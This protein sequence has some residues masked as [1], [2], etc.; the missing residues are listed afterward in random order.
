MIGKIFNKKVLLIAIVSTIFIF[1]F[2]YWMTISSNDIFR[3]PIGG[4]API[5]T[6]IEAQYSYDPD[7]KNAAL[8]LGEA[9]QQAI[10]DPNHAEEISLILDI[11]EACAK[12]VVEKKHF[13]FDEYIKLSD[14]VEDVTTKWFLRQRRYIRHNK[15]LSGGVYS[16]TE[17]DIKKCKFAIET[18]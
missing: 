15:N 17:P 13:A 6:E 9:L 11:A 2:Y 5:K 3:E 18:K 12:A 8:Q 4:W 7:L 16:L 14:Y 10:D 1:G